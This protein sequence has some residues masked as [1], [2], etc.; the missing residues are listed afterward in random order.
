MNINNEQDRI[1]NLIKRIVENVLRSYGL[2]QGEWHHG[3]VAEVISNKSLRVYVNASNV[4]QKIPCNP[5]V[6]FEVGSEVWVHYVNKDSK[7][8]F[9]PYKRGV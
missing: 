5:D 9:V 7:N 8:K 4:A 6:V 1:I 2:L 3:K